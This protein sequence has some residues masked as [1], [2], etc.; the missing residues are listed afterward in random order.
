[1]LVA[2][3]VLPHPPI[4]V[5]AV[6]A[7]AAAEL[8]ELR[9]ACRRAVKAVAASSPDVTY[10]VGVDSAPHATSFAPWGVDEPVDVPE[11]LPLPLLV[12]AWLT[13]GTSRSFVVVADE[14]EPQECAELGAELAGSAG[15]V[16]II[17]MGDGSARLSEKAPGYLDDRAAGYD[18]AAARALR[19]ADAE[20]LLGLDPWLARDLQVAGRAPWQVLAGAATALDPSLVEDLWHGAP[21][22]VGYHVVTWSWNNN[23]K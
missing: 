14:L 13:A 6:A 10:L 12:G 8:D 21:Y 4:L 22:G 5:P 19:Q 18:D 23:E 15:R 3:A 16:A 20:A 7:G 9:D 11:P 2:A 1:M 17:A